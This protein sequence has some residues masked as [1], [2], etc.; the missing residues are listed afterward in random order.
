M[1]KATDKEIKDFIK[2][3]L[4]IEYDDGTKEVKYYTYEQGK[5]ILEKYI[6]PYKK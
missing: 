5:E 3:P 4:I 2:D 6:L 1:I